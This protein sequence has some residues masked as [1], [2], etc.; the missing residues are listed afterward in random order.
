MKGKRDARDGILSVIR[1]YGTEGATSSDIE[2][3]VRI[4]RHTLSKYLSIMEREGALSHRQIGKGRLWFVN[5]APL[6]RLS[7]SRESTMTFNEKLILNLTSRI[8]AGIVVMDG[9]YDMQFANNAVLEKYGHVAGKKFFKEILGLGNADSL[10]KM[11]AFIGKNSGVAEMKIPD[12]FGNVLRIKCSDIPNPDGSVSIILILEDIT[13]DEQAKEELIRLASFPQLNPNPVVELDPKANICY[14]NPAAG[15]VFRDFRKT[16]SVHPFL[17]DITPILGRFGDKKTRIFSR[18]VKVGERWFQQLFSYVPEIQRI[19]IYSLDITARMNAEESL[20]QSEEMLKRSQ[21]IAHLGSWELDLV[22]NHLKWS[23][24]VYRIFG[25]KPQQFGATYEA[26]LKSVHPADRAA[27][28]SAY[29][30]S[31]REGKDSYE[32]EHRVVRPDGETRIVHEKCYH[33]RDKSGRI[34]RS[35]G[36]VHDITERKKAEESL[37]KLLS[38]SKKGAKRASIR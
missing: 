15:R 21:E 20:K 7:A 5:K 9:N 34:I 16:G 25:L 17:S 32:I 12:K 8:P 18:D 23:D 13:K 31:V 33:V 27:V 37:M 2:K 14:A 28:D 10:R 6:Q 30:G 3:K 11:N 36:M 38:S 35:I 29:S 1:E 26:F 4:E 22:K 19:R 24:E